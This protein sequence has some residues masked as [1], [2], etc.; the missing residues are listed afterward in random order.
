MV[1]KY[2]SLE[3]VKEQ[4]QYNNSPVVIYG[5]EMI[6]DESLSIMSIDLHSI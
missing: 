2:D 1:L 3:K 5:T 4:V 6:V